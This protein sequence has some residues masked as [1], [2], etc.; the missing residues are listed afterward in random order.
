MQNPTKLLVLRPNHFG[1][2]TETAANNYFQK[3]N[4]SQQ[5]LNNIAIEE[6]NNLIRLLQENEIDYN[7][8]ND[9]KTVE[10][11]DAIFLNNWFSIQPNGSMVIYPMW[12]K[13]RRSEIHPSQIDQIK[14]IAKPNAIYDFSD[15]YE[16]DQYCEGTGSLIFDHEEKLIYASVSQRTSAALVAKIAKKIGYDH[17]SFRATDQNG[18]LIYHTNVLLSIG[19]K[20]VVLCSDAIENPIEKNMLIKSLEKRDKTIIDINFIQLNHFC[21]NVLEVSNRHGEAILLMS[22]TAAKHFNPEQMTL[23]RSL[24]KVAY[25][26]IPTIEHFGGGSLRCMLA[27]G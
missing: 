24:V 2:N 15:E 12:A 7:I 14:D 21:A 23:M 27:R 6:H 18:N 26:A 9:L 11:P 4:E 20:I 10:N 19:K 8:I 5:Q 13:N 1:F 25:C 3:N 16:N 17:F 22:E